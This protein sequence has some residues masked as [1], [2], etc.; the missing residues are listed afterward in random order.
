LETLSRLL[1]PFTPFIADRIWLNLNNISGI[2]SHVSVHLADFPLMDSSAIDR[3]LE[4]RMKKAQVVTS[5]VRT[6]REKASIK[7]RQPLKRILLAAGDAALREEYSLVAD[8]ILEEVNVQKIEYIE[9]EGSVISKKV[10][11]NF[12]ALGPRF[13]KDMKSLAESIR[14]MSHKQIALFEKEGRISLELDG[15]VFE[16]LREDVDI[17]HEDIEGWLVASDEA[18][19]IMVAL[20]TEMNEELELQGLSRELVSRIQTLRKESGL[21]ITDRISLSIEG[22]D[23]VVD[24][25]KRNDAYIKAETLATALD[26]TFLDTASVPVSGNEE[27]VNGEICRLSLEKNA[28]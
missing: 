16:I 6:M 24:A 10:K 11:P 15:R 28:G 18:Y 8:I 21:E 5:L 4:R 19:G 7:V 26:V 17:M 14:C 20:D 27:S 3:P 22:T 25:V 12:K 13:G 9:E 1:A 2:D 23:K